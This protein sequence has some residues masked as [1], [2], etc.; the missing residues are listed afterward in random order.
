MRCT[1]ENPDITKYLTEWRAGDHE[2]FSKIASIVHK[3]FRLIASSYLRRENPNC[4]IQPTEL[5]N[6]SYIRLVS[7]RSTD[8]QN[9]KHF[10]AIAAKVMRNFLI[11]HARKRKNSKRG[12]ELNAVAIDGLQLS[13]TARDADLIKLDE[14]LTL[15]EELN[16]RQSRI[17]ELKFFGGMTSTEVSEILEISE[18]TV[19][20]DWLKAKVFLFTELSR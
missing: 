19:K 2:A 7:Q 5:V 15:L 13:V 17:V 9:R 14:A 20:R 6:E 11:D 16:E 1:A 18:I 8:W 4:S 3:E 10:Y 12:G